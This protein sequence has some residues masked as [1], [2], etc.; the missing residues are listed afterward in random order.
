[1]ENSQISGLDPY[2]LRNNPAMPKGE[3]VSVVYILLQVKLDFHICP[4][5][6]Y[7]GIKSRKPVGGKY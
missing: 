3:L 7:V 4:Y 5:M 6:E 1:M 2:S